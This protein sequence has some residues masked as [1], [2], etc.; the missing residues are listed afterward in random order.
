MKQFKFTRTQ[1]AYL[2]RIHNYTLLHGR[3]PS[4]AEICRFM[5]VS[6][7]S[8]HAMIVNLAKR[9]LLSRE[10]GMA[11]SIRVLVPPEQLPRLDGVPSTN[12]VSRESTGSKKQRQP[13]PSALW[14]NIK[15]LV[16][17]G[18]TLEIHGGDHFRDIASLCAEEQ[19]ICMF[20]CDSMRFE[21]IMARLEDLAKRY[22]EE[23][24]VTDEVNG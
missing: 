6:P 1:G 7:P 14:P 22:N 3:A 21:K 2:A 23:G 20:R 17:D 5:A 18:A 11:R 13:L 12:S 24:M 19:L 8:A 4:E 15:A 9:G 16:D 10:P